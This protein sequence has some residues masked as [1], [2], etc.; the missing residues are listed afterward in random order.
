MIF[1]YIAENPAI[2]LVALIGGWSAITTVNEGYTGV[3]VRGEQTVRHLK[4]GAHYY[5]PLTERVI[6][7]NTHVSQGRTLDHQASLNHREMCTF[8]V[9]YGYV[10]D[11]ADVAVRTL[12]RQ[13][14]PRFKPAKIEEQIRNRI[15]TLAKQTSASNLNGEFSRQFEADIRPLNDQVFE[16][17]TK[18]DH[19]ALSEIACDDPETTANLERQQRVRFRAGVPVRFEASSNCGVIES[20]TFDHTL[21]TITVYSRDGIPVDLMGLTVR[22]K[23]LDPSSEP[24]PSQLFQALIG[25]SLSNRFGMTDSAN[26]GMENVCPMLLDNALLKRAM[27]RLGIELVALDPNTPQYAIYEDIKYDVTPAD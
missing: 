21:P 22:Y 5:L 12:E 3:V 20:N 25:T 18:V 16:D 10:F 11:D 1:N 26:I 9:Q 6:H 19:I 4:P 2:M 23:L 13:R 7:V 14:P 27:N 8:R 15:D 24:P 17:G